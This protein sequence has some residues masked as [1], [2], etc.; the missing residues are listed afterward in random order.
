[1]FGPPTKSYLDA[2]RAFEEA[3][4]ISRRTSCEL[5]GDAAGVRQ[6]VADLDPQAIDDATEADRGLPA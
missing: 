3:S 1:M 2:R 5:L 4:A 6:L